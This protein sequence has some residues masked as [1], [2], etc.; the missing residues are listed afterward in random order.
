[1]VIKENFQCLLWKKR[2]SRKEMKKENDRRG[3]ESRGR[4]I[5]AEESGGMAERA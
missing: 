2:K 3:D 1:M 4:R 5:A